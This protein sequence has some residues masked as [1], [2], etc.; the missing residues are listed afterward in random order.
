MDMAVDNIY[1]NSAAVKYQHFSPGLRDKTEDAVIPKSKPQPEISEIS[2]K[3]PVLVLAVCL[4]LLCVLLLGV[5]IGLYVNLYTDFETKADLAT[6]VKNLTAD[7]NSNRKALESYMAEMQN[8]TT[9]YTDFE[10]KADLA[11]KVKNLT[12]D[13]N[14]NRK[15]LESYMAEMQ[16]MTTLNKVAFSASLGI[17]GNYGGFNNPVTLVYRSGNVN[18]GAYNS[19]TGIF[20]TPVRGVYFFM[21]SGYATKNVPSLLLMINFNLTFT[22]NFNMEATKSIFLN[23][24]VGDRVYIQ[25]PAY[26]VLYYS[27]YANYSFIGN[28]LY[29]L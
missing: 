26:N 20:T 15:A 9:L 3:R 25:L 7:V 5:I 28:L 19:S 21:I 10:T 24:G 14:S 13:V 8:M 16:N 17:S 2:W 12:A 27:L 23:L 29:P 4:G 6:K 22:L 11:T 1:A 18:T